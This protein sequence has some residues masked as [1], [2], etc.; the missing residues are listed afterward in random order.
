VR[1]P[2]QSIC[3]CPTCLQ[4][5]TWLPDRV[6]CANCR[7]GYPIVAGVP[8]LLAKG[9]EAPGREERWY[10]GARNLLPSRYGPVVDRFGRKL[11]PNL[12]YKTR[13]SRELVLQFA[14]SFRTSARVLN[15]GSGKTNFGPNLINLDIE[16]FE[17]VDVVGIAE[18]LPFAD[19]S[20]DGIIMIAVLEHV[21]DTA[22]TFAELSRV[23]APDG[24]VLIDVPFIQGYHGAPGDHRRYT[25]QG[26]RAELERYGFEPDAS[27]VAVGPA[28]AMAWVSSEFL[29]LLLSFQSP[30]AYRIVRLAT[31]W[32]SWPIK[33]VDFILA[34]HP[35][36][37]T[38]ASAVWATARLRSKG[39]EP[40]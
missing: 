37:Y 18:H 16:P 35:M 12:T 6:D 29:A 22:R 36:A 38:I 39:H 32:A 9:E 3:R 24:R 20:F 17:N 5:L 15:V 1:A 40:H 27:G 28:S 23:L 8:I 7:V 2:L 19:S 26:L 14:A 21:Q 13:A 11:R 25:E 30:T 34:R 10:T 31:S 4:E 33:Y